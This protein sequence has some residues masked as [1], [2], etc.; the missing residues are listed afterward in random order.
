MSGLLAAAFVVLVSL[1][2]G[3]A[4]VRPR[5]LNWD[6][7]LEAL[8]EL[9]PGLLQRDKK[10]GGFQPRFPLYPA[11]THLRGCEKERRADANPKPENQKKNI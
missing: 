4:I 11:E 7:A 5:T 6:L 3:L 1:Y 10:L 8:K 2:P 9:R